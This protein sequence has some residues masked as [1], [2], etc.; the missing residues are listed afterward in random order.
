M[1]TTITTVA[2]TGAQGYDG[3]G[4]SANQSLMDNPFHVE[5]DR[6][7]R[8]LFIADCFNYRVRMVDLQTNVIA[9]IAG[10]GE[11]GYSGDGGPSSRCILFLL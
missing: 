2:G 10:T 11:A 6:S 8:H 7:H 1:A 5:L 9:T 3:D 4:G